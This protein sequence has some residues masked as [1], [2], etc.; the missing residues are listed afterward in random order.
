MGLFI[1]KWKSKNWEKR[2]QAVEELTDESIIEEIVN[3]DENDE[4]RIA[5]IKKLNNEE[6]LVNIALNNSKE[7]VRI[8]AVERI[9]DKELLI[10]IAI[11]CKYPF[12]KEFAVDKINDKEIYYDLALNHNIPQTII[13]INDIDILYDICQKSKFNEVIK[14]AASK[15][16]ELAKAKI[17]K[18]SDKEKLENIARNDS[19]WFIREVAIFKVWDNIFQI[20]HEDN[21]LFDI[22]IHSK[23]QETIAVAISNLEDTGK[24]RKLKSINEFLLYTDIIDKR[25]SELEASLITDS[26]KLLS[27]AS[28]PGDW[29]KR[30]AAINELNKISK[31]VLSEK[32]YSDQS[33][34]TEIATK[35]SSEYVRLFAA[36]KITNQETLEKIALNRKE[37]WTVRDAAME[38]LNS[39][40]VIHK[41]VF[42][43]TEDIQ[44]RCCALKRTKG[45]AI[46]GQLKSC[47]DYNLSNVALTIYNERFIDPKEFPYL[48][49]DC[50]KGLTNKDVEKIPH[51]DAEYFSGFSSA[52]YPSCPHCGASLT[53]DDIEKNN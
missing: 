15:L 41:I 34:L 48:C 35:H 20:I 42:D 8:N 16:E 4:V 22:I 18:I 23:D 27:I 33:L 45:T 49:S 46:A 29:N 28:L 9:S 37:K 25:I 51:P 24:L 7:S 50:K 30:E 19:N 13:K 38:N 14:V 11:E 12:A 36:Q 31:Q 44:V 1:P 5:A 52:I 47:S 10:K 21:I 32:F 39:E 3:N 40:K 17:E 2:L 26:E 6:L 53:W 43:E